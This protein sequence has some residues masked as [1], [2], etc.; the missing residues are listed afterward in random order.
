MVY[1]LWSPWKYFHGSSVS[2]KHLYRVLMLQSKKLKE[3]SSVLVDDPGEKMRGFQEYYVLL[4]IV[5]SLRGIL[6]EQCPSPLSSYLYK[7]TPVEEEIRPRHN[8]S[9]DWHSWVRPSEEKGEGGTK[10]QTSVRRS[11][12]SRFPILY[13]KYSAWSFRSLMFLPTKDY[14][15]KRSWILLGYMVLLCVDRLLPSSCYLYSDRPDRLVGFDDDDDDDIS[16]DSVMLRSI[17]RERREKGEAVYL[18]RFKS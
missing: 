8:Q 10:Y 4:L 6:R 7:Y 1:H 2:R 15:R 5:Y 3:S 13:S 14:L 12:G 11:E 17:R 18:I 16:F 9:D